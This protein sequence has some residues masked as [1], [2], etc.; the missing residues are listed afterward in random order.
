MER[1]G[2]QY[3]A[4]RQKR[5]VQNMGSVILWPSG[6]LYPWPLDKLPAS[7]CGSRLLASSIS[8]E[9]FVWGTERVE[10]GKEEGNL[11]AWIK[12]SAHSTGPALIKWRSA[13]FPWR[14]RAG[15]QTGVPSFPL[16]A[17]DSCSPA[18]RGF[19]SAG[20]CQIFSSGGERGVEPSRIGAES[21]S[22]RSACGNLSVFVFG[23]PA[24]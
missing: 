2:K 23:S 9:R 11:A 24:A 13:G 14:T 8:L 19:I 18:G 5:V 7:A 21:G 1:Q 3:R 17:H 6:S 10:G 4:A 22:I 15:S 20:A 16:L 12:I